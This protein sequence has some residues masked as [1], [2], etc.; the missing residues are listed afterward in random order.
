[1][2]HPKDR[3]LFDTNAIIEAHRIGTW[4]ALANH[5]RVETVEDCVAETQTGFGNRPP[6]RRI[7]ARALRASL[8]TIH[9]VSEEER[10]TLAIKTLGIHLDQG[11]RSLLAHALGRKDFWRLCGPDK[12]CMRAATRLGFRDRLVSLEFLLESM[13]HRPKC[14][15]GEAY[16][17][18]W[19]RKN[20]EPDRPGRDLRSRMK[21]AFGSGLLSALKMRTPNEE[22]RRWII[23]PP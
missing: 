9:F 6:E 7:D 4:L 3:V 17:E 5:Y 21:P 18:R 12:A 2:A 14:P 23:P 19:L 20:P 13:R 10:A 15:F 11:E 16:T 1:M 8:A 22:F